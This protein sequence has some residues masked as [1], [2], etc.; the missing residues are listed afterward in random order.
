MSEAGPWYDL[1]LGIPVHLVPAVVAESGLIEDGWIP[2]DTATLATR[3]P[4]VYAL[5]DVAS[6]PVPKAGVFAESAARAVAAHLI[7]RVTHGDTFTPFDGRG[8]CY[9][10]FGG[11]Q[12]GR[13]DADF[14][15]GPTPTGPFAAA[16]RSPHDELWIQGIN[17]P[18]WCAREE[19]L[20]HIR[21]GA[22]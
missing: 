4:G 11:G 9:A 8:A 2:V 19:A 10:E 20:V 7:D 16:S 22:R 14:L 18:P 6:A 13:V 15:T 3:Y 5:G 12:V 17:A 1:F 21:E